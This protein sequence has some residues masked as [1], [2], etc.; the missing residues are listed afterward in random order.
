MDRFIGAFIR[1]G[2]L[3]IYHLKSNMDRFI[4]NRYRALKGHFCDLKSNMDRF[5]GSPKVPLIYAT[6][7]FKIQYG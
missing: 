7:T 3:R 6:P 5:I 4:V 1:K 2:S